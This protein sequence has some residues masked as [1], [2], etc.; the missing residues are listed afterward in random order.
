M[1]GPD[2]ALSTAGAPYA[3]LAVD[4]DTD[5]LDVVRMA[6]E[7]EGF[8]VSTAGSG[9]AALAWI[10]EHGLPH[11][12]VIDIVM[13]GMSGLE[14]AKRIQRASDVPVI[15][16]TAID[17]E[18]TVIDAFENLAEDYVTKPF[19]ARELAA[20]VKRVMRRMGDLSYARAPVLEVDDRLTIDLVR[21][22][23]TV[24]GRGVKLT[25]TETKLLH[26]L[27]RSAGRTVTTDHLLRR[28]W[29][30]EEVFED[31]LRVHMHRLRAKVEPDPSRP[32]Y[33]ST[34]RGL[35]YRFVA[36]R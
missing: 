18:D 1:A 11:L 7:R 12:A 35:G 3:V 24:D 6:L 16:L 4:D 8:E 26:I 15:L 23:A 17:D 34:Q 13:P 36:P 29:P 21:R 22:T 31:T 10:A 27:V 14:L 19:N 2:P 20:R 30:L 28:V 25:P 9:R 32:I 33:L 5:I